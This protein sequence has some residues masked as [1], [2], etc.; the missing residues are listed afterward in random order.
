M[1]F[2][3]TSA[4][5]TSSTSKAA[6]DD[7]ST[8]SLWSVRRQ[9]QQAA[10]SALHGELSTRLDAIEEMVEQVLAGLALLLPS[11]PLLERTKVMP[12]PP[13]LTMAHCIEQYDIGESFADVMVQTDM[14]ETLIDP[15]QTVSCECGGGK[16]EPIGKIQPSVLECRSQ[17]CGPDLGTLDEIDLLPSLLTGG[18]VT[19]QTVQTNIP[20]R[21]DSEALLPASSFGRVLR[22]HE[23]NPECLWVF[24][25]GNTD[26]SLVSVAANNL[27]TVSSM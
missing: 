24:F 12:S 21:L 18:Y 6:S 14:W 8:P 4:A 16:W 9:K 27:V 20:L 17:C 26:S 1:V 22:Q 5:T 19:G 23:D 10:R 15:R 25:E 2:Q 11:S 7:A 13:G 3:N